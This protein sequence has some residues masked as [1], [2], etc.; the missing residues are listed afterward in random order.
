MENKSG[1]RTFKELSKKKQEPP[2]LLCGC[3]R[4]QV[5]DLF[6]KIAR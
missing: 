5:G 6:L 3:Y 1:D 2:K 4:S